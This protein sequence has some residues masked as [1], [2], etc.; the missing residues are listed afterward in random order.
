MSFSSYELRIIFICKLLLYFY[1]C[2]GLCVSRMHS[3]TSSKYSKEFVVKN[4]S[5]KRYFIVGDIIWFL[6]NVKTIFVHILQS[7]IEYFVLY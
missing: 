3:S 2:F 1:K 7:K 6:V 4:I 5:A